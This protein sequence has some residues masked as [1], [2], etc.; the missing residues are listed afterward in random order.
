MRTLSISSL[1]NPRLKQ[2]LHLR[3]PRERRKSGLFIAE[4]WREVER[5]IAAGLK[6]DQ[7]FFCPTLLGMDAKTLA[8]RLPRLGESDPVLVEIGSNLL[9]KIAYHAEPEGLVALMEQPTWDI[10]R[11]GAVANPLWLVANGINKPGNLG[12]MARTAAAANATGMIAADADVDPFN[13]NALRAS[14]GAVFSL[15]I[16]MLSSDQAIQWLKAH[17][18]KIV[19][20]TPAADVSY[21]QADLR[22]AIAIAIGREETGLTPR[23]LGAADKSI[24]IPMSTSMVDSL[25]A[26][27]AAGVVLFEALRQRSGK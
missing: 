12:A 17:G 23:W 5:G 4:G 7:L 2:V 10:D 19:A 6:V 9:K 11:L 1:D 14:T 26:S 18:I 3:K 13:P 16:F 22:G 8:E 15:P 21:T 27:T 25:N 24:R 20:T